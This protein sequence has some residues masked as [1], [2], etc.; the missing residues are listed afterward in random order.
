MDPIEALGSLELRVGRIIDAEPFPEARRPAYKLTVDFGEEYGTR[1]SSAQITKYPR[2]SL[3]G[4]QVICA[5]NLPPKRIAGFKSEVLVMG[6]DDPE[7]NVVLLRPD[8]DVPLG[9]R[10]Y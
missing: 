6:V 2:E 8:A 5:F 3:P 4:R 10:V 9:H 7:G 1:R